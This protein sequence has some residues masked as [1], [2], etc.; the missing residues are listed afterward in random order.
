MAST[1]PGPADVRRPDAAKPML[2]VVDD[3]SDLAALIGDIANQVGFD[4]RLVTSGHRFKELVTTLPV[5][6]AIADLVMHDCDGI[7]LVQFLAEH[8]TPCSV[9]LMGAPDDRYLRAAETLASA[10]QVDLLGTLA[11][12]VR[13]AELISLLRAALARIDGVQVGTA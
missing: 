9:V 2:L 8:H 6:V 7:E 12:P 1:I 5:Q 3:E 4:A 13:A 10:W 11:K